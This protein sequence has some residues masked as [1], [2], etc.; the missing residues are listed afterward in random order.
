MK[1][2]KKVAAFLLAAVMIVI[3]AGCTPISF[4]K[5]WSYKSGDQELPIGVYIYS[6][7]QAYTQA[8]SY[9]EKNEDYSSDK[10][11]MD[12]TITDDDGNEKVAKD[13]I[14]DEADKITKRLLA[15][16]SEIKK[17]NITLDQATMDQAQSTA[18]NIWNVGPYAS[19]GYFSPMSANLEPYGISFDSFYISSYEAAAKESCLFE[20]IYGKGGTKEVSDSEIKDYFTENYTNYSFFPVSLYTSE[21]DDEGNTTNA[22]LSADEKK[23]IEDELNG[24]VKNIASGESYAD[25]VEKYME[26]NDVETDPSQTGTE[27]LDNSSIGDDIKNKLAEMKDGTAETL[28]VGKGDTA[29]LYFIYKGDINKEADSYIAETTNRANV[30]TAMKQDEFNDYLEEAANALEVEKNQSQ[31]DRYSPDMFFVPVEPE[32]EAEEAEDETTENVDA[33]DN[34]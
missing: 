26:A 7:Y 19:Y 17:N 10:S 29:V 3:S 12:L 28:H 14:L 2:F 9:A 18:E 13:W 23:K 32:T 11:F 20:G 1:P 27:I 30:L 6:L 8:Q 31:L 5:E 4:T 16:D 34:E 15:L 33:D 22:A 24:Y 21:T 25:V